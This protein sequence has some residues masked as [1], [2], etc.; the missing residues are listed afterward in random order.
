MQ[1][2]QWGLN[3]NGV[4]RQQNREKL[5]M[6]E[7]KSC[8]AISRSFKNETAMLTTFNEVDMDA[9]FKIRNKFK[10]DFQKT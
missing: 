10:D 9:V 7:K 1:F 3:L 6:L 4:E 8:R 5:S 2:H